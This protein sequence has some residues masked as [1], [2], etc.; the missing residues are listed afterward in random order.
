MNTTTFQYPKIELSQENHE[1]QDCQVFYAFVGLLANFLLKDGIRLD[2]ADVLAYE[3]GSF[4]LGMDS[5]NVG[6][7]GYTVI[8][9]ISMI[10]TI[11]DI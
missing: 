7:D 8:V 3:H 9:P 5:N 6:T 2:Y 11:T 10:D 4:V 1:I